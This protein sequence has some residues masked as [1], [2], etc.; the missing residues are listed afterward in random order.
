M[1][2][3]AS[4]GKLAL[5]QRSRLLTLVRNFFLRRQVLEVS[6]P[7]LGA[8]GVSDVHLENL[9]V[10]SPARDYY[11]QTSP[12]YAMKRLLAS[13]SGPIYQLGPVFR[14]AEIGHRHNI[15]FT[16]LEWY[17][18]GF[19]LAGLMLEVVALITAG[20]RLF[21]CDIKS[22][23]LVTYGD[24]FARQFGVNPHRASLAVLQGLAQAQD[25]AVDHITDHGDQATINDYLDTLFSAAI[26]PGLDDLTVVSDFPAGQAALARIY[27]DEHN[28]PVAERAEIYWHGCELANGYA[29]LVDPVAL[30]D[31]LL[32]NNEWRA[33]RGLHSV[34]LDEKLLA[35]IA[36]MPASAG[37][38][39]GFDRLLMQVTGRSHIDEV[40]S[41]TAA[42][43]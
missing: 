39:M 17:R 31:R 2:W 10:A 14:G 9:I 20:A 15:E 29:E 12:E 42:R 26:E 8:A 37:V 7:V 19:T 23:V 18:P 30:R 34:A 40:I 38:A 36:F 4:T 3:Q 6:T 5:Q 43:L 35:A 41:F 28:D 22:P 33:T 16:M 1:D 24:L 21:D 25:I 32:K 13:G 27:A 11:L